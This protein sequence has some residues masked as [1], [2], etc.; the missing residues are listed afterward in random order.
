[1]QLYSIIRPECRVPGK[2]LWTQIIGS[3]GIKNIE[4]RPGDC[5]SGVN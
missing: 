4:R 5:G 1:M 3:E 2:M